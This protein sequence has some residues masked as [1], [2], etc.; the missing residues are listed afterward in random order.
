MAKTVRRTMV[1]TISAMLL[2]MLLGIGIAGA[3][4]DDDTHTVTFNNKAAIQINVTPGSVDFGDV[5][6]VTGTYTATNAV[7]AWVRSN[8]NWTLYVK[9]DANFVSGGNT[10][11]IS[12]LG[13][14]RNGGSGFTVMTTSDAS[15]RTGS[16]TGGAGV[17][18][19]MDYQLSITWDDDVADNYS[20]TITYTASTP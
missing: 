10:I 4:S 7:N 8:T 11:P 2:V 19:S 12:R 13:W 1:A 15:V 3:A 5:D 6:P 17:D 18:T 20:A 16:K 9:G 14:Q